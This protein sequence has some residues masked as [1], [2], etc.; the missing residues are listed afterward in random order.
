MVFLGGTMSVNDP[1]PWIEDE[2]SLI[3][4]GQARGMPM[5][6]HCLGSQLISKALGGTVAPMPAKEIGWHTVTRSER[7]GADAWLGDVPDQFDILIW[8]HDAF[9][10]PP[11]ADPLYSS[12]FCP[13]Q[14]FVLGNTLATV[15]HIEVTAPLLREWLSIYGHDIAPVS[16]SV[17]DIE[18]IRH[19][20]DE[21]VQ[22]MH[23]TL[24][25]RLYDRW[26]ARLPEHES[27]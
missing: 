27:R 20:L 1:L 7:S 16:A 2:L 10:L 6:G 26:L 5:L 9:T 3:R 8:H 14:A 4:Q 18:Q 11:G 17:Q 22:E 25:D 19:R 21:R 24:T 12:P 15:A 13:D 23:D